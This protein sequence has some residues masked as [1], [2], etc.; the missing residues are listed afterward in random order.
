MKTVAIIFGGVSSEYE[1]SLKSAVAIIES[2]K[3]I[4][5]NVMKIGITEKGQWYLFEGTTDQI[6]KDRWF[7]DESCK[8]I[9]AD[10]AKKSFALKNSKKIIKP[11]ILFPVLHGGYGENGAIQGV[12]ELLDIPYVGCGIG[13]AAISMN[14]IMLHQFAEAIGVKSTPSMIIEK[15]QDLQKVDAFAKIHGFPLYIK[16]NEA[17]SSKGIS[18]VE[19]KSDLYKAI[20]EASNYDSRIL[21]QKEVKGVEIGCGILG[22]E[23]L[24]VGEC[25]QISLVDGFFDYEEKYNLVTAEI[26]LPAKLSIDKKEDIQIKAKKLYRL[27][28]CKGLARIDFFLTDDGEILLNEINTMP[29]F[30]EHSRFPMMM[31][32][33]GINYKEIIEKLLLLAVENHEK[34]LSEID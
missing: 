11:D 34:K 21:I 8:E 27:L 2:M 15:G 20:D 7:V 25:D 14:K 12:F 13:A 32:E 31:N 22:N 3:S 4:D 9:V 6:K 33:I 28:G 24:V 1:V 29:G 5:Y 17:G 18:K 23:Q 26:L 10:F 30:T 19:Q 16:P